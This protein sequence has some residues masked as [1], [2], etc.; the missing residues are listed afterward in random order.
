[1]ERFFDQDRWLY[2]CLNRLWDLIVLNILFM[3]TSLP[4]ITIGASVTALYTVT[5]K[6]VRKEDSY[7][8]KSYLEAFKENFKKA[9]VIWMILLAFWIVLL[10]DIL[11]YGKN[12]SMMVCAGGIFGV[13]WLLVTMYVLPL[14]ARFENSVQNMLLNSFLMAVRYWN[15]TLQ[16][17]GISAMI[18]AVTVLLVLK[19]TDMLGWFCSLF[20]FVGFSGT[21]WI[22]SFLYRTVFEK[23]TENNVEK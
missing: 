9:T 20:V 16:L 5:L 2:R 21:A 17:L 1:M 11:I 3:L 12:N 18:P 4:V 6:G 7:I 22:K 10:A 19:S 14:Q 23:V 13:F 8:V 15:Y